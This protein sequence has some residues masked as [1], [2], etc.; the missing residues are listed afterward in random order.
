MNLSYFVLHLQ[1][2]VHFFEWKIWA[3]RLDTSSHA[4]ES[5]NKYGESNV[6]DEDGEA[7]NGDE[8]ALAIA[9]FGL[10]TEQIVMV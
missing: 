2:L 7:R 9:P 3:E 1:A 8:P 10:D 4:N 5:G 6:G